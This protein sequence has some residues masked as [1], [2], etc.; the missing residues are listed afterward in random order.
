MTIFVSATAGQRALLPS[1]E[2]QVAATRIPTMVPAT[3]ARIVQSMILPASRVPALA[4]STC[5]PS[6]RVHQRAVRSRVLRLPASVPMFDTS[7][8]GASPSLR[9]VPGHRCR[10][11]TRAL[12]GDVRQWGIDATLLPAALIAVGRVQLWLRLCRD[13]RRI[14]SA[15]AA[16]ALSADRPQGNRWRRSD[17]RPALVGSSP[18]YRRS[19]RL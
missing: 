9:H 4:N 3:M 11:A 1:S 17:R 6:P 2:S 12:A 8:A 7:L 10:R 5:R 18:S 15:L 19:W 14:I 13:G 16:L